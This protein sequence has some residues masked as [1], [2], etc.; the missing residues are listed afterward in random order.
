VDREGDALAGG[1]VAGD[2]LDVNGELE[3]VDRGDLAL[4]VLVQAA[5]DLDLIILADGDAPDLWKMNSSVSLLS[6]R[7]A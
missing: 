4:L 1:L 2:A 5:D 3:A 6:W 7:R